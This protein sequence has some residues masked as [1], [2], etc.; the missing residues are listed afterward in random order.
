MAVFDLE[1]ID[2]IMIGL[3]ASFLMHGVVVVV[4]GQ[5]ILPRWFPSGLYFAVEWC[6]IICQVT[7]T[8]VIN[9]PHC[10]SSACFVLLMRLVELVFAIVSGMLSK[11]HLDLLQKGIKICNQ[12]V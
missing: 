2:N 12:N 11:F 6:L 1:G 7:P 5:V 9:G 3:K 8:I 10:V 4:M